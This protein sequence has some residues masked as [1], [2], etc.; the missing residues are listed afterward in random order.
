MPAAATIADRRLARVQLDIARHSSKKTSNGCTKHQALPVPLAL[1]MQLHVR[2]ERCLTL[3]SHATHRWSRLVVPTSFGEPHSFTTR[4][5]Y[6][7]D[8]PEWT[9]LIR[10]RQ[11]GLE[12]PG[13]RQ[14]WP[15]SSC[16]LV[17]FVCL[18]S[19]CVCHHSSCHCWSTFVASR[20]ARLTQH[21]GALS[22]SVIK[23]S[24]LVVLHMT[25][26]PASSR[27]RHTNKKQ[28]RASCRSVMP[29]HY[30]KGVLASALRKIAPPHAPPSNDLAVVAIH[31]KD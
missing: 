4:A 7:R 13:F 28:R 20:S 29:Q 2:P 27:T 30:H 22:S 10:T 1:C 11:R 25:V 31:Q 21:C 5:K 6:E 3:Q 14:P 15:C 18:A 24:R 8:C 17:D 19:A 12:V 9:R 16:N 23:F 26:N